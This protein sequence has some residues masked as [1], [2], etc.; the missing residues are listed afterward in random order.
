MPKI[1]TVHW[2]ER[3]DAKDAMTAATVDGRLF[4]VGW[5]LRSGGKGGKRAGEVRIKTV[6]KWVPG[7][8]YSDYQPSDKPDTKRKKDPHL[9]LV[10]GMDSQRRAT[11]QSDHPTHLCLLTLFLIRKGKTVWLFNNCPDSEIM[12]A[13]MVTK[14]EITAETSELGE[15]PSPAAATG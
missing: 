12:Y 8:A 1:E 7:K 5:R 13:V 9:F 15:G 4:S 11:G 14:G 6:Q 3:K 2:M 10:R